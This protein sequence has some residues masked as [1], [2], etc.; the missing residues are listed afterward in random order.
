VPKGSDALSADLPVESAADTPDD[1]TSPDPLL[2]PRVRALDLQSQWTT[3]GTEA[4]CV[5][6][7]I[8]AACGGIAAISDGQVFFGLMVI[9]AGAPLGGL[10]TAVFFGA[11]TFAL[12]L[13]VKTIVG[14]FR[15]PPSIED[16][17]RRLNRSRSDALGVAPPRAD[18]DPGPD[19]TGITRAGPSAEAGSRDP[20]PDV[21]DTE[22]RFEPGDQPYS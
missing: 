15:P 3:K 13:F 9:L 10:M 18:G 2:L 21:S 5:V 16:L 12:E 17:T 11:M 14:Y 19:E 4:G 8:F 1:R 7:I 22:Q 6:G 20:A